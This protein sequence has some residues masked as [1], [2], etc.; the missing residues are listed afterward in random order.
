MTTKAVVPA[1]VFG[2]MALVRPLALAGIPA[3]LA[4]TDP[5]DLARHSRHVVD[6]WPLP[7][8]EG[9]AAALSA[10]LLVEAAAPY[11]ARYGR[12]LPV[13]YGSDESQSFVYA[14]RER[15]A[16][17]FSLLLQS[18]GLGEAL[19]DKWRFAALA[20]ER[21]LLTPRTLATAEDLAQ[22]LDDLRPPLLIKP[23]RKVDWAAMQRELFGGTGKARTFRDAAALRADPIFRRHHDALV[24][25]EY[26]PGGEARLF[27]FHGFADAASELLAWF[28]G[29]KVRTY[30]RTI[31]ESALI[32]LVERP[33]LAALGRSLVARLGLCGPFKIDLIQ[34]ERSDAYYMLEVNARSSLWH[35][36][37]AVHGV[38][39]PAIAHRYLTGGEPGT[40]PM[41]SAPR[42][43]WV[44]AYRDYKAF[45]ELQASGELSAAQ[46]LRSLAERPLIFEAFAWDDPLPAL[47]W[48]ADFARGRLR[49]S[50][51]RWRATG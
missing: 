32:E 25:Q 5:R 19:L 38:N 50:W 24:V 23:K 21:G 11:V 28:C 22:H 48:A 27:S 1:V 34:D 45:R 26:I 18:D 29:R 44:S 9:G 2:D 42:R 33:A 37:G 6:F 31:G 3:I 51:D 36:L 14:Q 20:R 12:R 15:L 4:S 47:A 43:R 41:A 30:P 17:G 35:Y 49:R 8:L 39:L 10:R 13:L 46:W 7:G 16:T 40:A